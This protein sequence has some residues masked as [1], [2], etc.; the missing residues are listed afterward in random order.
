MRRFLLTRA[1][2]TTA[3]AMLIAAVVVVH[4]GACTSEAGI[5]L[6]EQ[7]GFDAKDLDLDLNTEAAGATSSSR[8]RRAKTMSSPILWDY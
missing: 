5:L 2:L 7:V 3:A 8:G 4:C 6:P 1:G